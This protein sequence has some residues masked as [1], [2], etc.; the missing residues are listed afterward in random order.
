MQYIGH[1]RHNSVL[2]L[3]TVKSTRYYSHTLSFRKDE[4]LKLLKLVETG[5]CTRV[6]ILL[7]DV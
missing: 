5:S 2:E 3:N 6:H 1:L 7:A 4:I